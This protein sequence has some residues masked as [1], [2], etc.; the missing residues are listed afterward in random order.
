[1]TVQELIDELQKVED[2]SLLVQYQDNE[3]GYQYIRGI[4]KNEPVGWNNPHDP[5]RPFYSIDS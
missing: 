1:M 4:S 2:K 3:F 5:K